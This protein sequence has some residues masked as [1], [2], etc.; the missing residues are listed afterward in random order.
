MLLFQTQTKRVSREL[1]KKVSNFLNTPKVGKFKPAD[2]DKS[3][4]LELCKEL[5]DDTY[6]IFP[7]DTLDEEFAEIDAYVDG[8][9][10]QI[11]CRND[12]NFL[13]L[14]DYKTRSNGE[15]T[16]WVDRN[17]AQYTLFVF[18][19]CE[20]YLT[21]YLYETSDLKRLL[22][23]LRRHKLGETISERDLQWLNCYFKDWE[24]YQYSILDKGES[25]ESAI[26]RILI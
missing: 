15:L 25:N 26:F 16:S 3:L 10:V 19:N 5:F 22:K 23:Q 9:S 13:T 18:A 21:Y 7:P 17:K 14:E 11:K 4:E 1:Y 8:E 6:Q 12:S 2:A 20:N 24:H